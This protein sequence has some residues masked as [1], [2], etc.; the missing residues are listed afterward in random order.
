MKCLFKMDTTYKNL[1]N[2]GILPGLYVSSSKVIYSTKWEGKVIHYLPFNQP[3]HTTTL[4]A[5]AKEKSFL[6]SLI[7]FPL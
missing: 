4:I 5:V 6:C 2:K 3:T 1:P 7:L